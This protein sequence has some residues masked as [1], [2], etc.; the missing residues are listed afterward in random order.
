MLICGNLDVESDIRILLSD[1]RLLASTR[2][3][4]RYLISVIDG[5][6]AQLRAK[7]KDEALK[8]FS[9]QVKCTH[10]LGLAGVNFR[11]PRTP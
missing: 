11:T 5:S 6:G 3:L 1:G 10:E 2:S 9:N 8:V 4:Y 7:R